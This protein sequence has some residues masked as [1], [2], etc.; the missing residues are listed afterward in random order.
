MKKTS[1]ILLLFAGMILS[2]AGCQKEGGI[3]RGEAVRFGAASANPATRTA[4]SGA[5]TN[6]F[7]RIDWVQEEK[8]LI[9]S[10]KAIDAYSTDKKYETYQVKTVQD[11]GAES[12]ATLENIPGG[13]GLQWID[14]V[15]EFKFWGS[16]PVMSGTPE[17]GKATFTIPA[18]QQLATG[19]SATTANNVTTIP[20]DMNNAW[21][22]GAVEGAK[23]NKA[24]TMYFYP[25][26]TAFEFTLS[27]D[28][29]FDGEI[30]IR[31]VELVSEAGTAGTVAATLA[32]GTRTNTVSGVAHT[33]GASTYTFS[34]TGS[35]TFTL[36]ANTVVSKTKSLVFTAFALPQ[37]IE[38]LKVKFNVTVEDENVTFTGTMKKNGTPIV[39]GACEKHRIQ[40]VAVPG[41]LWKIYYQPDITVDKW[42]LVDN[43]YIFE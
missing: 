8:V 28:K 23:P 34:N 14:G 31:S 27:G 16:S 11:A 42:E 33:I 29:E 5:V 37:N 12:H 35:V 17:D 3:K 20:A 18:A 6:N 13:N 30:T 10:D 9:W 15:D 22:L 4:Y 25:A 32:T 19:A 41:N 43:T 7:E 21:L 36:P 1:Y 39:F 26:F 40:G 24:V 38:G 2:L